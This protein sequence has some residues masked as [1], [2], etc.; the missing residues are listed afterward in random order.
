MQAI[1]ALRTDHDPWRAEDLLQSYLRTHP[2]GALAEE[3][4][5]LQIE[6]ARARHD[7]IAVERAARYLRLYPKG[8]Y[9]KAAE[10]ALESPPL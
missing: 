7:G 10:T 2:R 3:A 4:L 6:A 5:A 8:A 9:R 1:G